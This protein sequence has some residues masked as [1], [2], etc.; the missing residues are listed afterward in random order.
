[1]P[2][3]F[4]HAGPNRRNPAICTQPKPPLHLGMQPLKLRAQSPLIDRLPQAH[5]SSFGFVR[6]HLAAVGT[7]FTTVNPTTASAIMQTFNVTGL[8]AA[9]TYS[10][11]RTATPTSAA[12]ISTTFTVNIQRHRQHRNPEHYLRPP[13]PGQ[14]K[15]SSLD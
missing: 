7:L 12:A 13:E 10:G 9:V 2:Q 3:I 6:I 14:R 8:N 15:D 4:H 1:M 5:S 11:E